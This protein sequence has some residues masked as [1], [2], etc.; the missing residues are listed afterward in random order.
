VSICFLAAIL[1]QPMNYRL[2]L[3]LILI[4]AAAPS[5]AQSI[6]PIPRV[7]PPEG[8]EI[9]AEVRT[10][11]VTR[12]AET[13]N[14]LERISRARGDINPGTTY[15][16]SASPASG[17]QRLDAWK[18]FPDIAIFTK[19]VEYALIHREFYTPKD[20]E[21]ADWT[22]DE[23]NKRIDALDPWGARAGQPGDSPWTTATGLVLR[24]M[25]SE[26]DQSIQP[27]GL[28]VPEKRDIE[29]PCPLYVWL[30]G[31]GD[32]NTDLHFLYERATRPGQ[33]APPGAIV[34]HVF[35]RQCVGY[36]SAGEQDVHEA[37][38]AVRQRYNIDDNRKV[39]MG[40][41]MG[42]AG[43]WQVGAHSA[44]HWVAISP[45]AGFA[46]TARYQR[47]TPDRYPPWYEQKLWGVN[48]VPNYVRNL[49]NTNVI[50]YSGELD[51]QIQAARVMEEAYQAE[52][53]TL[54]HLIGPGVE[55]KY[56]P[57]TL[58]ELMSR[59]ERIVATG[60]DENP[61]EAHLQTRTLRYPHQSW[62]IA[63]ALEEHWLDSRID[64]ARSDSKIEVGTK[65]IAQFRLLLTKDRHI[66]QYVI[67]GQSLS[68]REAGTGLGPIDWP[69]QGMTHPVFETN[70]A[71]FKKRGGRWHW[72]S[73]DDDPDLTGDFQKHAGCQGPIDDAFVSPFLVVTPTGKSRSPRFQ[74]WVDFELAHFRDRWRALMRGE[75]PEKRDVDF[76]VVDEERHMNLILFGDPDS[77]LVMARMLQR[78][79]VRF[80]SGNWTFGQQSLPGD[81]YVPAMVFPRKLEVGAVPH[82]VFRYLVLNSGLTFREG[83]DRTNSQ[84]NPKLPDW[85][86]IDI[87]KP[88]D[89]FTPGRI[90]AAGF[91][92]EHW[93]LKSP[94]KAP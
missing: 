82:Y 48:D 89:A 10:R 1:E 75:L 78:T 44:S 27:Y 26:I 46:E 68:P 7:L 88:P 20:F 65:N 49:F 58:A 80:E 79:P 50:A 90:H 64:A 61:S 21:K 91:F 16:G 4:A 76:G 2:P 62:V 53:R 69:F 19:A 74:A 18:H 56:E 93:Q 22:L 86:I 34:L 28:V 43:A 73:R 83:H 32:R 55:H 81:S 57:T 71:T 54:T 3:A 35:G 47:L 70:Q 67:D 29:R 84:Q 6:P 31:R 72:R 36:K 12:L 85:A 8:L 59:L 11:L 37:V 17:I 41:S 39:L 52:G 25:V 40:F 63:D 60:R 45:G 51:R 15:G 24:G 9:P 30:H 14:R 13:K 87:T 33:I 42:G 38:S 77:N 5:S 23:A 92:D 94:P 66:S